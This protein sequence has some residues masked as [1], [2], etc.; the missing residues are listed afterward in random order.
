ML[1]NSLGILS[2]SQIL[3]NLFC[4][5][6]TYKNDR[7]PSTDESPRSLR[8]SPV[9]L[10]VA[11]WYCLWVSGYLSGCICTLIAGTL[12]LTLCE[13]HSTLTIYECVLLFTLCA[14][15]LFKWLISLPLFYLPRYS[16]CKLAGVIIHTIT[17]SNV[18]CPFVI[19][20]V[21]LRHQDGEGFSMYICNVRNKSFQNVTFTV[22]FRN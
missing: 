19:N 2:L 8:Y 21:F 3:L 11:L 9:P 20:K 16:G 7:R 10:Y 15:L 14:L 4:L 5:V 6:Q 17:F 12:H 13:T 22:T 18:Y 1:L